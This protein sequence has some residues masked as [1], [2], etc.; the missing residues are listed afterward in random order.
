MATVLILEDDLDLNRMMQ[1]IL[2][3]DHH[4][5]LSAQR[6]EDAL[7]CLGS[8]PDVL[9][10]DI[11]LPG[12]DGATFLTAAMERGFKG[13][14]LVVSGAP[15][16]PVLADLMGADAYLKKPFTFEALQTAVEELSERAVRPDHRSWEEAAG[17]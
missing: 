9:V 14:V 3:L 5:V 4:R 1:G 11:H 16:S 7:D 12:M 2:T 13:P 17:I 8:F 6:P 15:E 10:L